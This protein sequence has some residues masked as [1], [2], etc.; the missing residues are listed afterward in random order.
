MVNKLV[1]QI[2]RRYSLTVTL[3]LTNLKFVITTVVFLLTSSF[4]N[5][6][7]LIISEYPTVM[8]L[9]I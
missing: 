2:I 7:S 5:K 9:A 4:T 6:E 3:C 8:D 1:L